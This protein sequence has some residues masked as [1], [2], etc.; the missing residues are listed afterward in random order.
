MRVGDHRPRAQLGSVGQRHTDGL[1]DIDNDV[2]DARPGPDVGAVLARIGRDRLRDRA[3]APSHEGPLGHL[4]VDLPD[5]VVEQD[6]GCTRRV[7]S[8]VGANRAGDAA[9]RLHLRRLEPLLE[10]LGDR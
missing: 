6:V 2:P 7:R 4:A 8:A 9:R 5:V 3:R 1:A 10:E